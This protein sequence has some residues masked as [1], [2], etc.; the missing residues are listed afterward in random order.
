MPIK[1]CALK[2]KIKIVKAKDG[3]EPSLNELQIRRITNY[4]TQPF[5]S[6]QLT[7]VEPVSLGPKPK[8]LSN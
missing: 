6:L 7:G 4:A 3:V 1:L 2:E 5:L 8:T